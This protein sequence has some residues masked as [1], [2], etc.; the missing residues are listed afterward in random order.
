M[1]VCHN[2]PLKNTFSVQ[3]GHFK[4]FVETASNHWMLKGH[5]FANEVMKIF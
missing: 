3:K 1:A 5:K 2:A 4:R